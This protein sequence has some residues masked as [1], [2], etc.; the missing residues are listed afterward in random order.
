MRFHL[1]QRDGRI[2]QWPEAPC[3]L[4]CPYPVLGSTDAQRTAAAAATLLANKLVSLEHRLTVAGVAYWHPVLVSGGSRR[5]D[6]GMW[7]ALNSFLIEQAG[8]VIVAQLPGWEE[9]PLVSS[10]IRAAHRFHKP[11]Y[12]LQIEETT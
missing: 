12:R 8:V 7:S 1:Y 11:L 5:D 3:Y 9:C 10:D 4:A 6:M 2:V